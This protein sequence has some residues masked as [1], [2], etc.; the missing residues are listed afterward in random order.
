MEDRGEVSIEQQL[1]DL[2]ALKEVTRRR[3]GLRRGTPEWRA[4]MEAELRAADRVRGWTRGFA[5]GRSRTSDR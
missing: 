1:A 5:A 3:E 4:A 2:A